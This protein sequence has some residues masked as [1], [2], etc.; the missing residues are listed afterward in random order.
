MQKT[1][2]VFREIRTKNTNPPGMHVIDA[3]F[4]GTEFRDFEPFFRFPNTR[5]HIDFSARKVP[6]E[7]NEYP[8]PR[9]DLG[10][11]FRLP[12]SGGRFF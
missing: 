6:N 1:N 7:N 3:Q 8:A 12:K 11:W 10:Y 9:T 5:G 4:P 2:F